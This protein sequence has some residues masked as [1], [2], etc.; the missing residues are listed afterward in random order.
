MAEPRSVRVADALEHL[1]D[2]L[3]SALPNVEPDDRSLPFG[4]ALVWPETADRHRLPDA[5]RLFPDRLRWSHRL[6]YRM[7]RLTLVALSLVGGLVGFA[8]LTSALSG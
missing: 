3:E 7:L 2:P 6:R 8:W 1:L 4:P 5:V